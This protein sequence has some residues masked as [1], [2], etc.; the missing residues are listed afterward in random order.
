[1]GGDIPGPTDNYQIEWSLTN[2][3]NFM[4]QL[5]N[6]TRF[7][8]TN[9]SGAVNYTSWLRLNLL[10]FHRPPFSEYVGTLVNQVP[11]WLEVFGVFIAGVILIPVCYELLQKQP[12]EIKKGRLIELI[13]IPI[14]A[15]IIVFV[16]V[17]ELA[18]HVFET[19]LLVM[20][21]EQNMISLLTVYVVI[22][23]LGI[24]FRVITFF[25]ERKPHYLWELRAAK[26]RNDN[27]EE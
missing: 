14:S 17:Y 8:L 18:L 13:L 20:K 24:V 1:V 5:D 10:I 6:Q 15:S 25:R 12:R 26:L 2:E 21:V 19:P 9:E 16:P 27:F 22:L 3:S 23:S 7:V 4:P 11:F